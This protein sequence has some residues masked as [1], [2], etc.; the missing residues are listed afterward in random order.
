M[1]PPWRLPAAVRTATRIACTLALLGAAIPARAE[2]YPQ[3]RP[4]TLV[5]PFVA[6]GGTDAL[7]RDLGRVLQEKLG[8][9][10]IIDNKGGAGG[11]IAAQFVAKSAPD[12][13]TLFFATSTLVTGAAFDRKLPY[14]IEKDLTPVALLGR[15][16]LQFDSG[17]D[18]ARQGEAGRTQL[19]VV[20]HRRHPASGR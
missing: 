6:G 16:P 12:G 10:I 15:G 19:R 11:V 17:A 13:H 18:R 3:N 2:P 4:I 8:Q 14:D 7:A 20:R 5:V 1:R 9:T